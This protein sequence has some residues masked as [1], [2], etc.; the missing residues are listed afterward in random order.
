MNTRHLLIM[1]ACCLIPIALIL[2]ISIFGFS[3]GTLTPLLPYALV[4]MCPLMMIFMMR[5][6]GHEH[7]TV[8]PKR[9]EEV[10]TA[11]TMRDSK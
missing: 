2:A 9:H 10:H 1:L 4:L 7:S 3:L 11:E 5:G 6:M 8:D